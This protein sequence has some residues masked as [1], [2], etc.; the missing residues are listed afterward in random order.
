MKPDTL[1]I[2]NL[3]DLSCKVKQPSMDV[4]VCCCDRS[5]LKT[6]AELSQL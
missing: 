3:N 5:T 1:N 4:S 2:N 6:T